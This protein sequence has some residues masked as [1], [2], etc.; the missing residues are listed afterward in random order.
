MRLRKEI[1]KWS[2]KTFLKWF[3]GLFI[4]F[5]VFYVLA[6]Y[7]DNKEFFNNTH[8]LYNWLLMGLFYPLLLSSITTTASRSLTITLGDFQNIPE[9][10]EKLMSIA[11]QDFAI[12]K[13]EHNIT[14]LKPTSRFYR[15]IYMWTQSENISIHWGEEIVIH[16]SQRK[17]SAMEDSLTWNTMFKP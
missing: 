14:E 15:L 1:S 13:D 6:G 11:K 5:N 9:F 12:V 2:F 8:F 4:F 17:V 7:V 16:G 3:G 10:R